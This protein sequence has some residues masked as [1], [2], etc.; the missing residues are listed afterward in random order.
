MADNSK[1]EWTDLPDTQQ[2]I[3]ITPEFCKC[4]GGLNEWDECDC[5]ATPDGEGCVACGAEMQVID[6]ETGE[7]VMA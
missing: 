1:I 2:R 7:G 6:I 3:C 4:V 5:L